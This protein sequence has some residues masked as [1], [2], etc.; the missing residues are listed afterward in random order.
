MPKFKL[1]Y[2]T[3]F[4]A[5]CNLAIA[6]ESAPDPFA[7]P[8]SPAFD[9]Q[10]A[11]PQAAQTAI[12]TE[13]VLSGLQGSRALVSLPDNTVLVAV[14]SGDIQVLYANGAITGPIAGMP[15]LRSG[16]GRILMD[17]TADANFAQNRRIFFAYE[18]EGAGEEPVGQ[19]ASGI[20]SR[21]MTRFENI[22]ILGNYPGRRLASTADGKLYI[23][24]IG[25]MELRP[26][27]MDLTTYTGK[28]LRINADGSVPDDNPFIGQ[29]NV[30]PEIYAIGHR[31]QDGVMIHPE[32]G[33][34]WSIEHGPMGGDELN[35]VH[36]GLNYGWPYTTY[37][38]NYDGTEI[39]PS[40]WDGVTQPLYYWF[41]SL[42]PSG[43]TMVQQDVFP[44]WQGN[45]LVGS[46]SPSQGRFLI[47]LV[48]DG[49]RVVAE[50]HLLVDRDRR[51][52]DV[53]ETPDG[54]IYVLLD[55][56]NNTDM[57]RVYPGEV[58]KLTPR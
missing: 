3:A 35:A 29:T 28:V 5:I 8:P 7:N 2:L 6:A 19:I 18:A 48:M 55:S 21:D 43:L 40:Q 14:G 49:E 12:N 42:A 27:V 37:G 10:T 13:L 15:P 20:L 17:I 25:Y 44:G 41:P 22:Q 52:R 45:L 58:L 33:E 34:L 11:A 54:S 36:A 23:T 30:K 53:T 26:E 16:E 9:G 39:G 24:T 56:E 47:R 57:G 46:L 50:E 4:A 32:T 38:K 1:F 31:D 51:V